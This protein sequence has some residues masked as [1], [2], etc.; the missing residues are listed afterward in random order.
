MM[1]LKGPRLD[2]ELGG[3]GTLYKLA[4][5]VAIVS[6]PSEKKDED[7]DDAD[8]DDEDDIGANEADDERVSSSSTVTMLSAIA[9]TPSHLLPLRDG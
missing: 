7:D 2:R 3:V 5:V 6:I 9:V 8:D 4:G 1:D